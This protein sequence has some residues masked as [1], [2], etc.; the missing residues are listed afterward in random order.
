MNHSESTP[1]SAF[2][3]LACTLFTGALLFS[4]CASPSAPK[5]KTEPVHLE[6]GSSLSVDPSL[7][8]QDGEDAEDL[9][10]DLSAIPLESGK[11]YPACGEYTFPI[12]HNGKEVG[13]GELLIRD[14]TAPEFTQSA[15][16]ITLT[17]GS[18]MPD[19][20][21]Y[22]QADDLDPELEYSW[23]VTDHMLETHGIFECTVRVKDSSGNTSSRPFELVM[24]AGR[25]P[26]A[27]I[28]EHDAV[29][30]TQQ[31]ES[32]QAI[33]SVQ[34]AVPE[35]TDAPTVIQGILLAN[36]KHPLP[37][38]FAPG[39]DTKAGAAARQMIADMQS[40]GLDISSSY[41]GYRS[42]ET[43]AQLYNNYCAAS[44]QAAADTF[45]ARPGYSEHQTGLA[46]DLKH[47]DGSLVE[48]EP[49]ASWIRE[50]CT[51]YGFILRYQ[52]GTEAITGYMAEPW[53]LR[54]IGEQA[55][56]IMASGLTLE[57]YLGAEG[58]DY[59]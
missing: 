32:E 6:Y 34:N 14:T 56:D 36:K 15:D 50:H 25:E 10:A 24:E 22:F 46:F 3:R 26:D 58:G 16:T 17:E 45:S 2:S 54:W 53:H 44:G 1:P 33:A 39:E 8:V 5:L 42:Y 12:L 4:G 35:N 29:L 38:G 20:R 47:L 37:A 28:P 27:E 40:L 52:E 11:K 19:I 41:S 9:T 57:E 48:R 21:E 31:P 43:Q 55:G 18:S 51:D 7:L 23:D 49:E 13:T 59:Q 30:S